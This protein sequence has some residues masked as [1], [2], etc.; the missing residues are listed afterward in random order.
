[1]TKLFLIL[2]GFLNRMT[3]RVL[4]GATFFTHK[5]GD[6]LLVEF[7]KGQVSHIIQDI[8]PAFSV[9]VDVIFFVPRKA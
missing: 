7:G 8:L 1:M 4:C 9:W 3:G 5:E 2:D 6:P